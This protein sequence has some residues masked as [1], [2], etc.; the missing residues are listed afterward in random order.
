MSEQPFYLQHNYAPIE[1]EVSRDNLQVVGAIPEELNGLFLR[2]GPNPWGHDPGHWF[3]GDGMIH[4]L[5]LRDGKI[6]WYRNR[7]ID[8]PHRRGESVPMVPRPSN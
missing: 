5:H 1:H 3:L 7:Y 8:T 6:D 4:G 2:N